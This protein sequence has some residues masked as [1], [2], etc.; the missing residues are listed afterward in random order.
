MGLFGGTDFR[1]LRA[2]L[3]E[4][5]GSTAESGEP[6][7]VTSCATTAL[8]F[9][10]KPSWEHW[11]PPP[12]PDEPAPLSQTA[13]SR[14][15]RHEVV[16]VLTL[17]ATGGVAH[18]ESEQ[19]SPAISARLTNRVGKIRDEAARLFRAARWQIF[20]DGMESEFSQGLESLVSRYGSSAIPALADLIDDGCSSAEAASEAL[21]WIGRIDYYSSRA[22][23]LWL[24]E[25]SLA[26]G[27]AR[28]RDG[29]ALGL[30]AM[31]EPHAIPFVSA[32]IQVERIPELRADL[33]QVLEQ[34]EST[35]RCRSS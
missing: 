12:Q 3:E 11:L 23:R 4:H 32:A 9:V 16:D 17:S 1:P 15:Y 21:R 28:I 30:A 7:Q 20:E 8:S 5:R 31:D 22:S 33:T 29:A 25:R 18:Q 2:T 26:S 24:L 34:L 6:A 35:R 19:P 13:L 10:A 27:S 14:S